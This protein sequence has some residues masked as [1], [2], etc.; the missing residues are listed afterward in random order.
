MVIFA[1]ISSSALIC[2][3]IGR[4]P[5]A[6]P[7]GSE[8]RALP[9]R[10]SSGPM[11]S[12]PARIL[13]T[14]SYGASVLVISFAVSA[15]E[16]PSE[17]PP[18]PLSPFMTA[19]TPC[20]QSRVISVELA[21]TRGS[22]E[23]V[24]VSSVSRLATISG[25]AEFFA[26]L[27]SIFPISGLPPLIRILSILTILLH[28]DDRR[29][30]PSLPYPPRNL[31]KERLIIP[32]F[33]PRERI[34][35][36]AGQDLAAFRRDAPDCR[37]SQARQ[38]DPLLAHILAGAVLVGDLARLV[39]FQE[40]ELAGSFIGIDFCRQRRGVGKF[41]R[42]M[43]FPLR[44]ERG[45]V[46]D[47]AAACI[48]G[49]AEADDEDIARDAEIFDG[50]R[51]NKGIRRNN[52]HI[53]LAIN[54]TVVG[55]GFRIDSG[56]IDIG[57]YLELIGN[58]GVVAIGGKTI[59]DGAFALLA[60]DKRLDHLHVLRRLPD[61]FVRHNCHGSSLSAQTIDF[62]RHTSVCGGKGQGKRRIHALPKRSG[63]LIGGGAA[64]P[65]LR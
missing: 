45:H 3:F 11:T 14:M 21:A 35:G 43:A 36:P 62:E 47:D 57:E 15:R 64:S 56:R 8:T 34:W 27:I 19:V 37:R 18:F 38:G 58:P 54:E 26:P 2:K 50:A 22:L 30:E 17:P 5:M 40:Q 1:P 31:S 44:L 49:F 51:K 41:Q 32:F 52:A 60:F 33:P 6:Q 7:P 4:V 29:G 20:W 61:P 55:E 48:G 16:R 65:R 39:S 25:S 46:D 10:A 28:S 13:R 53:R 9:T 12:A 23:R 59:G 63:F 42:H 24:R